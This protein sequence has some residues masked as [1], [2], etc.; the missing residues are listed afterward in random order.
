MQKERGVHAASMT[1]ISL[2][3]ELF[4]DSQQSNDEAA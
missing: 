4:H 2:R 1:V 3:A